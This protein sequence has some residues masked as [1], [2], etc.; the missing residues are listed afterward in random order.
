M[1]YL[2]VDIDNS[3]ILFILDITYHL[4]VQDKPK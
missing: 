3:G 2:T 4:S 1:K